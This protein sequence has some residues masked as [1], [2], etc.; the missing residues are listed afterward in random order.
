[1]AALACVDDEVVLFAGTPAA[2]AA[3]VD[4]AAGVFRVSEPAEVVPEA[5]GAVEPEVVPPEIGAEA[6]KPELISAAWPT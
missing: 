2:V 1:V 5:I 6:L 4:T 3:G